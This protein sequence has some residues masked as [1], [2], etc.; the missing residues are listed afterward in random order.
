MNGQWKSDKPIV[1][2]KS[3]NKVGQ[4]RRSSHGTPCTGKEVETPETATGRPTARTT[5]VQP[6]AEEMEERGLPKGNPPKQTSGR[7]QSR[8]TL[9][10]ALE[11]IR[12]VA[13]RDKEVQFTSLWHRVYNVDQLR[14]AY[15]GLKRTSAAGEDGVTWQTY[16][17]ALE[18]NLAGLSD[19]LARGAYRARPVKRV[20]IP[21]ADGRQRPIGI[22]TLEDKIVQRATV[23]VL[24]AVYEADFLGFSYGFRPGR[25]PHDALDALSVGLT[26]RKVNWV[27]DADIRGFFDAIDHG[28]LMR[29]IEHRIGDKRV[30]R[31]VM[32]WLNAGVLEEG[33]W[34][35]ASTGTPQ[36]GS[37]SPLLANVYLHYVLDLWAHEWRKTQA[38]GDVIIV[39]Y[40]DDFVV[41]FQ[42]R[43]DAVRFLSE[44]R[45][46]LLSYKLEL[47]PD[48]TRL[49]EF[50]RFAD[51]NR[52]KRGEGKPETFDF[53]GF[54]HISGKTR[55]G[56]FSV[57]R[58]TI[59]KRMA[60]KLLAIKEE[61]RRRRHR[62]VKE[63][64]QWLRTVLQGHFRYY[65]VPTNIRSLA[66][67]RRA[68]AWLWRRALRRRSQRTRM[69]WERFYRIADRWLPQP[70]IY[71]PW[72]SERLRVTTQ[73]RSPVR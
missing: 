2:G 49:L 53:L 60:A 25:S 16:G 42:H 57:K 36:G 72:P 64:G 9:Q 5:D 44:L 31:H 34:R 8:C 59:R 67:M 39:R 62:P 73:G 17:E 30:L 10:H 13:K 1:P 15:L 46:R 38:H 3:P 7:I 29:F 48:K 68:V 20:Y 52:R 26:T 24:N 50:G 40:A 51:E 54:T 66:A 47:H 63:T 35:Q 45:E 23:E 37:I 22:P 32:K 6:M 61:L 19:R 4:Q 41:G 70:R 58:R 18:E 27:L 21:K 28:C 69:T 14:E 11:R 12:Q 65:G 71:H 56:R 43:N 55:N 33:S